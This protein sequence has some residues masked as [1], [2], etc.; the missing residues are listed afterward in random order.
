MMPIDMTRPLIAM[1]I[2]GVLLGLLIALGLP[3]MWDALI[4]PFLVWLVQ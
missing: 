4:K 2:I 1:V 3:W